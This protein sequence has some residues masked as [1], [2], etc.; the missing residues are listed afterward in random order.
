MVT[1]TKMCRYFDAIDYPDRRRVANVF[2][3]EI[4][5]LVNAKGLTYRSLRVRPEHVADGL[6]AVDRGE[7]STNQLREIFRLIV[8]DNLTIPMAEI[9]G[10]FGFKQLDDP[11]EVG[12][13]V[14]ELLEESRGFILA[15]RNNHKRIFGYLLGR[16][17]KESGNKV[18]PQLAAKLV[19][20][21]L[22]ELLS[23]EEG[24]A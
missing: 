7:I 1:N 12:R 9:L 15:N 10:M 20:Q 24:E 3:S 13:I 11:Q 22:N 17:V 19:N 21:G 5:S 14:R 2:F 6:R 4:V 23:S 16:I 18:N 8:K